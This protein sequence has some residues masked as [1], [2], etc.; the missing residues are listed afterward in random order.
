MGLCVLVLEAQKGD[1][2]LTA[3]DHHHWLTTTND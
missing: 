3:T 1:A 2:P